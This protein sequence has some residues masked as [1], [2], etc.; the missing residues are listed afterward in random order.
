MSQPKDAKFRPKEALDYHEFP[1]PGKLEI[2]PTKPLN[3]DSFPNRAIDKGKV[4]AQ[5]RGGGAG[6][7]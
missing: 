1:K 5:R 7:W 2:E 4:G 3:K 6:A